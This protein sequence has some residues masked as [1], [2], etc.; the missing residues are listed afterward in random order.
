MRHYGR[1]VHS[2]RE[3]VM[4]AVLKAPN[5][6]TV[7]LVDLLEKMKALQAI[8]KRPEFDPLMIGFKRAHRL[9]TKEKEWERVPVNPALFQHP[10]EIA[11]HKAWE[12][13]DQP[14][15]HLNV[16]CKY[17]RP[18]EALVGMKPA[19]D[20]FFAAVMVNADDPTVRSN[21]LSLLKQVDDLF[22][23]FADFSQIVV[24]GG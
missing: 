24:Q 8:T 11:L 15:R 2:L 9:V 3:D 13:N 22:M 16:E 7:D 10:S 14:V 1:L 17:A 23:S 12:E 5:L 21:R 18:L 4:E 19:I 6:G 20:A